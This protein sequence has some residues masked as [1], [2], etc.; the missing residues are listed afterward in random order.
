MPPVRAVTR[1]VPSPRTSLLRPAPSRRS[2]TP[3]A[4]TTRAS[5]RWRSSR[6]P[7]S[8]LCRRDRVSHG[9][10]VRS[11]QESLDWG[12]GRLCF[13]S[14]ERWVVGE[15]QWDENN[16]GNYL[17]VN[18]GHI[19]PQMFLHIKAVGWNL[20]VLERPFWP[21]YRSSETSVVVFQQFLRVIKNLSVTQNHRGDVNVK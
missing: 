21:F 7:W 13:R 15:G 12:W 6:S 19:G 17:R 3:A 14:D 20:A 16:R 5:R 10:G 4:S 11:G 1:L 18:V 9:G 2:C 8:S